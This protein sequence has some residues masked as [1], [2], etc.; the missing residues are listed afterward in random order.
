MEEFLIEISDAAFET[1]FAANKLKAV[2]TE[3]SRTFTECKHG[4]DVEEIKLH[5]EHFA[6]LVAVILDYASDVQVKAAF[7]DSCCGNMPQSIPAS[8]IA[9]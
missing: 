6:A 3:F 7:A 5:P 4:V 1:L 2:V 8:K 9:G